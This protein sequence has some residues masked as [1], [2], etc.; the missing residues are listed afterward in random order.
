MTS[1][2]RKSWSRP[3]NII[4]IITVAAV[5]VTPAFNLALARQVVPKDRVFV[6]HSDASG[7]CPALDWHIVVGANNSLHGMIAWNNMANIANVAGSVTPNRTFTIHAVAVAGGQGQA[8]IV[9]GR[10]RADGWI[11]AN[12]NGPKIDCQ[13][14]SVPWF[15]KPPPAT[16][17]G[18]G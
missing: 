8:A 5:A 18:V 17:A 4:T 7:G 6:Y 1:A 14:I 9:T 11:V 15:V 3:F 2:T 16:G 13:G 12:I 10:V